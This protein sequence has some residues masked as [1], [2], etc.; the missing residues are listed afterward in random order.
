MKSFFKIH[1]QKHELVFVFAIA[2]I[3]IGTTF[4]FANAWIEPSLPAPNGNVGAP[5]T[6]GG[7]VQSKTGPLQIT[8]DNTITPDTSAYATLGVTGPAGG[9]NRSYL[10]LTK[11][12]T[13]PWGIGIDSGA[14]LIM[15]I[16]TAGS[17][18]IASPALTIGADGNVGIGTTTPTSKLSVGGTGVVGAG[19]YGQGAMFGVYGN[20]PTTPVGYGV[21]GTGTTGVY[22]SGTN[23]GV[24]GNTS[25]NGYGVIGMAGV[26]GSGVYGSAGTGGYGITGVGG[27]IGVF[28]ITNT[29]G[30]FGLFGNA[31]AAGGMGVYGQGDYGTGVYGISSKG[32][33]GYFTSTSGPALITGTGNVGIGT[34]TPGAKLDVSGNISG[35]Y[36]Y[37]TDYYSRGA[38]KWLSQFGFGRTC[39]WTADL[40]NASGTSLSCNDGFYVA[41]LKM[42]FFNDSRETWSMQCCSL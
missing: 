24:L 17:K 35:T 40:M 33:G 22:G 31:G 36:M 12:G 26:N 21:F 38:G 2:S 23:Y 42:G 39:Y 8:N 11:Q 29:A 14:S 16:S 25:S 18:T 19:I 4:Q 13:I 30:G 34:T 41:G 5:I 32:T 7:S 27:N 6:T 20:S 1:S 15:G 9:T 28:G 37:A 10:G 3:I